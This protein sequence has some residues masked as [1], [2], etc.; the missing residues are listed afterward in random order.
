[1]IC[2]DLDKVTKTKESRNEGKNI[3]KRKVAAPKPTQVTP[4]TRWEKHRR[5]RNEHKSRG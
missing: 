4:E 3:R 2:D 5:L 1:M